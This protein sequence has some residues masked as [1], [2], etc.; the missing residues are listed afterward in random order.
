MILSHFILQTFLKMILKNWKEQT[1]NYWN[2]LKAENNNCH[3]ILSDTNLTVSENI[4]TLLVAQD[5]HILID[6]GALVIDLN[7]KEFAKTLLE[8]VGSVCNFDGVVYFNSQS[9]IMMVLLKDGTNIS[10]DSSHYASNLQRCLMYL[11]KYH[12]RGTDLRIPYGC[13]EALALGADL[14]KDRLFQ[15]A[16]RMRMLGSGHTICYFAPH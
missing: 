8:H 16:M 10:L 5:I 14:P 1:D 4:I 3:I 6:V 7:N 2:L 11:D 13:R 15:T 12:T 9:G